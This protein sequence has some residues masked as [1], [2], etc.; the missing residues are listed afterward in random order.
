[1][2]PIGPSKVPPE[3]AQ[4]TQVETTRI[5]PL[6]FMEDAVARPPGSEPS[7]GAR[8]PAEMDRD[9]EPMNFRAAPVRGAVDREAAKRKMKAAEQF[10]PPEEEESLLDQ[11]VKGDLISRLEERFGMK[12]EKL[13]DVTLEAGGQDL[14]V[15]MRLPMYDDYIWA[16]AMI[17]QNAE[18]GKDLSVLQTESQ[19]EQMLQHIASC[20]CVVKIEGECL[21]DIFDLREAILRL[22]PKWDGESMAQVPDVIQG[23]MGKNLHTLFRERLH[24]DLLFEVN[25]K[26]SALLEEHGPGRL[27]EKDGKT[28]DPTPAP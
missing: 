25:S 20:R 12:P 9:L 22:N 2:G 4:E 26:V 16:V 7:E 5:D 17:E 23:I 6:A 27:K 21:W 8:S 18:R 3:E 14:E 1:M 10:L 28:E 24:A 19:R 15:S 11:A 13:Y